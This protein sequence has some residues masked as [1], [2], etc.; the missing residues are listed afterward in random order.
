MRVLFVFLLIFVSIL[1]Q[2]KNYAREQ[3]YKKYLAS[4]FDCILKNDDASSS[5]KSKIEKN[6]SKNLKALIKSFNE[7][8][9]DEDI[10]IIRDCRKEIFVKTVNN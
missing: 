8:L 7:G 10:I 2:D 3:K 4:F 1:C 9:S 6:D 5:L